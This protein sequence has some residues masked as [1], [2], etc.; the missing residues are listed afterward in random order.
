MDR[1]HTRLSLSF[2]VLAN[3][4]AIPVV[5]EGGRHWP[6]H[7]VSSL[8]RMSTGERSQSELPTPQSSFSPDSLKCC[9]HLSL[10]FLLFK[11]LSIVRPHFI[12]Y[13]DDNLTSHQ[14][15]TGNTILPSLCCAIL[16][17]SVFVTQLSF[18]KELIWVIW[19]HRC[20]LK[21]G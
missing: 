7:H 17:S 4:T 19:C 15:S 13:W 10:G 16:P 11:T 3:G 20:L 2:Q 5:G 14:V 9:L 1:I 8:P 6:L 12:L 21:E 18:R